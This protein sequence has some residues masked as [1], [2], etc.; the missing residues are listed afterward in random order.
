MDEVLFRQVMRPLRSLFVAP[1]D[2][3][4]AI[5]VGGIHQMQ[6]VRSPGLLKNRTKPTAT[7]LGIGLE[8]QY[9]RVTGFQ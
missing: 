4:Q 1:G 7:H 6:Y 9:D 2:P 3:R 8:V 5:H